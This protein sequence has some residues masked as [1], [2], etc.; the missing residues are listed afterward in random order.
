MN[1]CGL[2]YKI[3]IFNS[4]KFSKPRFLIIGLKGQYLRFNTSLYCFTDV[5]KIPKTRADVIISKSNSDST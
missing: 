2:G 4:F 1:V 5:Q 3:Y